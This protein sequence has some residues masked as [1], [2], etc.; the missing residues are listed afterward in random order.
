M[1]NEQAIL[2]FDT[3]M[4]ACGAGVYA[5]GQIYARRELMMAGH[6]ERLVPMIQD[7]LAEAGIAFKDVD[8]I[9]TT[10]GPGA[11][12]GL[13]IGLS[14]AKAFGFALG[15]PV[16]G[17]STFQ[18]LASQYVAQHAGT[19]P[20]AVIIETKREDFY[21]QRFSHQAEA[22][23]APCAIPRADIESLIGDAPHVLIGDGVQ[24]YK[25]ISAQGHTQIDCG[26]MAAHYSRHSTADYFTG[27][28]EPLYLRG[29]EVSQSK[30]G[31]RVLAS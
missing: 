24:R 9:V 20:L 21:F 5:G 23:S 7:V 13:R 27:A 30:R 16:V 4:N 15:I 31:Q 19:V 26:F 18:M 28:I 14:S 29:A 22:L 6:G 17:V 12:T 11:F 1:S 2:S 10:L 25:G 3:S 8:A